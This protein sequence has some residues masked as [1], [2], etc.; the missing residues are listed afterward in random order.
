MQVAALAERSTPDQLQRALAAEVRAIQRDEG[1]AR[2]ERQRRATRL[3][4][5]IDGDGMWCLTGRF[6]P[7]TGTLQGRRRQG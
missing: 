3:R 2:L 1:M 4:T 5:W 7:E 6:D